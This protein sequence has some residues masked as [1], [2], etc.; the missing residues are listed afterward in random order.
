MALKSKLYGKTH[1][2]NSHLQ[3]FP[4]PLFLPSAHGWLFYEFLVYPFSI[5]FCIFEQIHMQIHVPLPLSHK[6][7]PAMDVA[8]SAHQSILEISP[9]PRVSSWFFLTAANVPTVRMQPSQ[10]YGCLSW[11]QYKSSMNDT[12][13]TSVN[14]LGHVILRTCLSRTVQMQ[15]QCAVLLVF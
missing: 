1:A 8:F 9:F 5:S 14:I 2:A 3:T 4:P 11:Q 7:Q 15:L 6:R 10:C 13:D 12:D